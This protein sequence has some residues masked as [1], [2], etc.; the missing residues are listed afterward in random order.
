MATFVTVEKSTAVLS[1]AEKEEVLKIWR[2]HA[3]EFKEE[4]KDLLSEYVREVRQFTLRPV[5]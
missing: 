3:G 5:G 4:P 1:E 2:R